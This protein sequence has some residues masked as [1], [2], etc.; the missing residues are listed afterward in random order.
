ME[1]L[2]ER[3]LFHLKECEKHLEILR[4]DL[5]YI[6]RWIPIKGENI[7]KI[8][9]TSEGLKILDQIAYRFSKFQDTLGKLVKLYL[10]LKGEGVENLPLI[11]TVNLAYRYGFPID[12]ELWMEL[13]ILRNSIVHDYPESYGEIASALNR[14]YQLFPLLEEAV[15][16]L[17]EKT[18]GGSSFGGPL[19]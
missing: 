11:D 2:K 5:R 8:S 19:P 18:K 12:G 14:I 9:A 4:E 6:E 7:E 1:H 10:L 15:K 16:F 3:F 17:K 13:R